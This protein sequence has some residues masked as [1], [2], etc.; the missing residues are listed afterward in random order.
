M[1]GTLL[2]DESVTL[3]TALTVT[4]SPSMTCTLLIERLGPGTVLTIVPIAWAALMVELVAE[5][6]LTRNVLF[7]EGTV[8]GST[9]TEIDLLVW[10]GLNVS[11]PLA[12]TYSTPAMAVLSAVAY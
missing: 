1:T 6:R 4:V 10:P 5:E 3:N 11:V 9:V 8:E 7:A 12:A 2:G